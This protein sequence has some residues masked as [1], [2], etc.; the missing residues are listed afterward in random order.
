MKDSHLT[1]WKQE[2]SSATWKGPY[3]IAP[4]TKALKP[5]ARVLDAGCG[6]GKLALPLS[7]AGF[8]VV[9]LDVAREGLLMMR[10]G[11]RVEG[12]VRSLPFK[13]NSFDAVVCYD[14]IQHLLAHERAAAVGEF[15]RITAPGG[16]L[17]VEAFG[18]EDMRYGGEEVEPDTF[19]RQS[20]IIYHYFSE[21]ELRGLLGSFAN[22][23]LESRLTHRTFKGEKFLR[24][25]IFALAQIP[26]EK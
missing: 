26:F 22:I 23:N 6:S 3:D 21:G 24:H 10:E 16:Y 13:N 25:R 20:G 7:R 12:D 9:C 1:A 14:V 2:Y 4:I 8:G 15:Y 5:G 18:R 17:F 11:D 19:R